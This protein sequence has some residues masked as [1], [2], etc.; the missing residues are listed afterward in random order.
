MDAT[1]RRWSCRSG[2][3]T[4]LAV[5]ALVSSAC[6]SMTVNQIIADPARESGR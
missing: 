3:L 1:T 6:A 2:L 5:G 4:R